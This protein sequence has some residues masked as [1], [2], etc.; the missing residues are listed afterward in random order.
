M[1]DHVFRNHDNPPIEGIVNSIQPFKGEWLMAKPTILGTG[2]TL[3]K[4]GKAKIWILGTNFTKGDKVKIYVKKPDGTKELRWKGK[5]DTNC[6]G[7][8]RKCRAKVKFVTACGPVPK[9]DD[10]LADVSITVTNSDGESLEFDDQ[11]IVDGE[12]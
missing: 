10:D 2:T 1:L 12:D 4:S 3:K 5:I 8:K 9:S 6:S 7:S 11:V